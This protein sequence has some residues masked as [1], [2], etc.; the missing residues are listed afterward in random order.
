MKEI[1]VRQGFSAMSENGKYMITV[2]N[3]Y[4]GIYNTETDE[5]QEWTDPVINYGLGNG[6]MVT[7]DGFL[8][9]YVNGDPAILDIEKKEWTLLP[10]KESDNIG[11]ANAITPSRDIITGYYMDKSKD[12]CQTMIKPVIWYRQADGTY[13]EAEEMPYPEKDFTGVMPKYILPN[14][15]SADGTVIAAQLMMQDNQCLPL[16]YRKAHDGTWAY[17]VYD[18]GLCEPG[19]EF[20]EFP[21]EKPVQPSQYDYMTQEGLEAYKQDSTEYADSLWAYQTGQSTERPKYWPDPK[22][23]MTEDNLQSFNEAFDN[24]MIMSSEFSN[25][26][27]EYRNF[28]YA[29][30]TPNFYAQNV[31]WLSANGKYYATTCEKNYKSGD[32]ALFTVGETLEL[33]DFEDGLQ[34]NSVTNDGDFFVSSRKE[35]TAYVYPAGSTERVTLIDWLK[36][37]GETEAAEWLSHINTGNAICSGDGRVI[38]GCSQETDGYKSWIVKLDGTPTGITDAV[39]DGDSRVKVY[40]LQG[41][42]VKEGAANEVKTGLRRGIYIINNKKVVIK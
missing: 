15:I 20:P 6:N 33:H 25:K 18:K 22:N 4:I 7:N 31:V 1:P 35:N 14:C 16:I 12:F 19:L 40:D 13:S 32:A 23:Y 10:M 3:A 36:A 17:E 41:R 8:V 28:F 34:G 29:N 24:Y 30:V 37:K 26:L 42:F 38:S 11:N 21:E 39:A 27:R 2:L 5:Y 9:G